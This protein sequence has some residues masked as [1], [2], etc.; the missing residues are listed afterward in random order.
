VKGTVLSCFRVHMQT[1]RLATGFLFG[2]H[3][4]AGDACPSLAL[5]WIW[6]GCHVGGVLIARRYRVLSLRTRRLTQKC[7]SRS[8]FILYSYN[9]QLSP[10]CSIHAAS[11]S[12]QVGSTAVSIDVGADQ[13]LSELG[14]LGRLAMSP[15]VATQ[16]SQDNPQIYKAT[17]PTHQSGHSSCPLPFLAVPRPPEPARHRQ[18]NGF[19]LVVPPQPR[20]LRY[21]EHLPRTWVRRQSNPSYVG[22]SL[23]WAG[24][25][26]GCCARGN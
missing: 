1:A 10:P 24:F 13:T 9:A 23:P 26:R 4:A 2:R 15:S 22:R 7:N 8:F 25:C 19:G 20:G 14:R 12:A 17:H 3:E 21:I 5:S 16:S 6:D 11:T 18:S